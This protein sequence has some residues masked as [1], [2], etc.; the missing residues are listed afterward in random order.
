MLYRAIRRQ[1]GRHV[2]LDPDHMSHT[3]KI[4]DNDRDYDLAI[5]LG[6]VGHPLQALERLESAED[7]IST[8]A[9]I[10][11]YDDRRLS[12]EAQREASVIESTTVRHLPEIPEVS[13]RTEAQRKRGRPRK[14]L[15]QV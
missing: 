15:V 8:D 5:S 9:A 14:N 1:D 2:V 7:A 12:P 3:T 4:V 10:R 11:A 13:D 6:W